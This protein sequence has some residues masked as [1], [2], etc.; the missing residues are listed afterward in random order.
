[1]IFKKAEPVDE[2]FRPDGQTGKDLILVGLGDY[3]LQAD[4]VGDVGELLAAD[5]LQALAA[6]LELLVD[7]DGFLS[8]L[9]M[10]VLGAADEREIIAF[11]DALVAVGIEAEAKHHRF[12]F[13]FF[14][15]GH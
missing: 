11:G 15:V 13:G 1:V 14:G 9:L 12:A 8:H 3:G 2:V 4:L 5:L 10:R 7:L 6:G